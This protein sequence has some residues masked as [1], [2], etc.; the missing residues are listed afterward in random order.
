MQL[1]FGLALCAVSLLPLVVRCGTVC[2][3]GIAHS[4]MH[5]SSAMQCICDGVTI[6]LIGKR[7]S[8]QFWVV[9]IVS[10]VQTTIQVLSS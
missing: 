8:N 7:C 4:N 6:H 3:W 2:S 1:L 9:H 10:S 5:C